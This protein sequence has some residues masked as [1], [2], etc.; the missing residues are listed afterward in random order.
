MT[1]DS[2]MLVFQ[3]GG[4]NTE[5]VRVSNIRDHG[6]GWF[7][8]DVAVAV[9]SFRG[10]YTAD[11]NSWAFS[12][13]AAQLDKLYQTV[14]GSAVFTS[15]EAQLELTLACD[16]R[17]HIQ[18]RGE[19][20]DY[21]GTGNKLTFRLDIDQTHVPAILSSLRSAIEKYPPRAV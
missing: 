8:A 7:S 11:F 13:F 2:P 21:A 10:Q 16:A 18:V 3:I 14:S 9:G 6:D 19:A 15:Y 4:E 1:A 5:Y 20:M 12:D 17:G